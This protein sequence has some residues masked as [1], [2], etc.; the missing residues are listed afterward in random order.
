MLAG[1]N[2]AVVC[3]SVCRMAVLAVLPAALVGCGDGSGGDDSGS[4]QT[5]RPGS[6]IPT[7][8]SPEAAAMPGITTSDGAPKVTQFKAPSTFWCLPQ[9]PNRAQ[10]TIGWNV[11]SA[12]AVSVKLDGRRI[13]TG[14]RTALPFQ[15]P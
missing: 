1:V 4:R 2:I 9:S 8:K 11:P 6:A 5:S 12:T 15:V 3:R 14:I 13:P 10:V 7:R